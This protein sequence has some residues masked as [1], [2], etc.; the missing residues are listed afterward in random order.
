MDNTA[1]CSHFCGEKQKKKKSREGKN[2]LKQGKELVKR[3]KLLFFSLVSHIFSFLFSA[4]LVEK[5]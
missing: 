2:S 5:S 1:A 3:E 4:S